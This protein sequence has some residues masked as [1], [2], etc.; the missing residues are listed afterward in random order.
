MTIPALVYKILTQ[1]QWRTLAEQGE[2]RGSPDDLRD[3][4]I[5]L[6]N[7][8]QVRGTLD[9]HFRSAGAV[10][11]VE[12]STDNMADELKMEVSRGGQQ[13]PHLYRALSVTEVVRQC[14]R[15]E[16]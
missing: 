14:E 6:S 16:F 8:A 3:G 9:K 15:D 10:V 4:F 12:I 1:D 2:F 5:H 13:F 7:K 11:I